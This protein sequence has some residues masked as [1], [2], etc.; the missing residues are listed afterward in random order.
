MTIAHDVSAPQIDRSADG[1]TTDLEAAWKRW[2]ISRQRDLAVPHGWLSLTHFQWLDK[3]PA[4]LPGLPGTFSA[5]RRDGGALVA[6]VFADI[7]DRLKLAAGPQA[8]EP[9]RGE[10]TAEVAEA[11][12]LLWLRYR[13]VLVELVLRGGRYA[14]RVRDPQGP[15]LAAFHGIPA[16]PVSEAWQVPATFTAFDAPRAVTVDTARDDLRQNVTAVGTVGFEVDG[17]PYSLTA[18]RGPDDRLFVSFRDLTNGTQTAPWRV[19]ATSAPTD[20]GSLVIDFNRA[21]N[22]PFA[23]TEFGTCPAPVPG[24]DLP[25]AVTAGELAPVRVTGPAAP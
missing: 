12:S 18:T 14:V 3:S 5:Q 4:A 17:Q 8:G 15:E 2:H 13:E 23:F 19:V 6:A 21:V 20:D 25:L 9:V 24:N 22:L 16:F 11:G 1:H 10:L 7:S